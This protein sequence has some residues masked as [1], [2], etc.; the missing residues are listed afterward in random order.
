MES[1]QGLL[2]LGF[3]AGA[4]PR[5]HDR[6]QVSEPPTLCAH[7]VV[8]VQTGWTGVGW[9]VAIAWALTTQP[10]HQAAK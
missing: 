6:G 7:L 3:A 1:I 4:V 10:Q 8:N 9:V 2:R 5:A